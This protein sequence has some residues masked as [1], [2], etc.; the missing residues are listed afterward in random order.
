METNANPPM[1]ESTCVPSLK[2]FSQIKF[3]HKRE[4]EVKRK[5]VNEHIWK[6]GTINIK[7]QESSD[8]GLSD[9]KNKNQFKMSKI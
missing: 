1:E 2:E 5:N 4:P 9:R 3:K 8:I 7:A 6:Q